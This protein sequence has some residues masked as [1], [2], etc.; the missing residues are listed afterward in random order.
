MQIFAIESAEK[1]YRNAVIAKTAGLIRGRK[2]AHGELIPEGGRG[3]LRAIAATA[4]ERGLPITDPRLPPA[5][6][7]SGPG[8]EPVL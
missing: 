5:L 3:L 4:A 1:A 8:R 6:E 7:P 2:Q